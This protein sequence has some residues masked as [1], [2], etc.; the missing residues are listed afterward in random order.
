MKIGRKT[1]GL[2][3]QQWVI[4]CG[5]AA[6]VA[7]PS[8]AGAESAYRRP[9]ASDHHILS[10][11]SRCIEMDSPKKEAVSS[12]LMQNTKIPYHDVERLQCCK[13]LATEL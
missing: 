7:G 12:H 11:L 1:G 13:G 6:A 4:R 9:S 3:F 5:S 10:A 2:Y 8:A